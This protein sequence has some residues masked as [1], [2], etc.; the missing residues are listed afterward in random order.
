[1]IKEQI[2][3]AIIAARKAKDPIKLEA[4]QAVKA[5]T[6]SLSKDPTEADY[7]TSLKKIIKQYE[8]TLDAAH[9]GKRE[10]LY[11][12]SQKALL[13]LD[14]YLPK[15]LTKD[16]VEIL[17]LYTMLQ[18]SLTLEKK[19]MGNIVKL[20]VA[21]SNGATDGKTVSTVV[22]QLITVISEK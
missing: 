8:E 12:R 9:K 11:K 2:Q 3:A 13:S 21:A 17:V 6:E 10:D 7:I 18:N 16:E 4:L 5:A 22:S 15:A 19:N 14:G 1:M 20:T